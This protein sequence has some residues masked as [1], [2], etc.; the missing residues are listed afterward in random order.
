MGFLGLMRGVGVGDMLEAIQRQV[1]SSHTELE[2][3]ML[4]EMFE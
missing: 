1:L 4:T 2:K 3:Y